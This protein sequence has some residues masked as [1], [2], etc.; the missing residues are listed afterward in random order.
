MKRFIALLL[1]LSMLLTMMGPAFSA[2]A[3]DEDILTESAE[4]FDSYDFEDSFNAFDSYDEEYTPDDE[5]GIDAT[6]LYDEA[7]EDV[8]D[9]VDE[10]DEEDVEEIEDEEVTTKDEEVICPVCGES[11]L[12]DANLLYDENLSPILAELECPICG[13]LFVFGLDYVEYDNSTDLADEFILD[14]I[15]IKF[16]EPWQVPGKEKQLQKE[17]DKVEK[18]GFVE[19][20]GVYVIKVE[21]LDKNPNAILNR[22]KNNS[23]IEYIEPNYIA[24]EG[25]VPNDPNYSAMTLALTILNAQK[26]WDII[27]GD[28]GPII[29][30][31]DSGV[32]PH[33]DL[34]P[35]LP[36]Y[37]AVAGLSPNNDKSGHGTGVAGTV[38]AIGDN[39]L[40]GMGINWNASIL[41]VKIDDANNTFSA[42]NFAK[43]FIWAADNGAKIITTSI[44]FTA[45]ST[46]VKNAIDYA[47]G[48]GCAIFASAGNDGKN[49]LNYPA[50]YPNV[51]AVGGSGNGS[52]R[53]AVSNYG[54]GMGVLANTSYNTV[55]ASGGFTIMSGTSFSTPQVAGLAS[56][57][58]ALNPSLTNEGVYDIIRQ[59]AKG[60]GSYVN[61]EIGYG[62][63][64]IGK[65]LELAQA[66]AGGNAAAAEAAA[67]AAAD[68]A[69][70]AAAEAAAKAAAE[71]A[72]KAQAEAEAKAKAEA[73][74][75]AKAAAEAAAKAAAEAEA[76]AKAEAEAAAKAA[77]EAEAKA[78]AEAEAAAKAAAEAEAKAAAEAEAKAKAEAEAAAKAAAEAEAAAKAA[79]E[80]EAKAKAE[81]EAAA[82][83][84]AEA[85]A[86]KAAAEAEA[87]AKAAAEAEAQAKA[88][89]E[90]EAE[91]LQAETQQKEIRTP[92]VISLTG[93]AEMTLEYDQ[94]YVE[95]G[96]SAV[97]CKG[98]DLTASVKVT[99][100]VNS[101]VAGLYTITYE[102]SDATN[103]AARATRTVIVAPKPPDPPK[104]TAPKIT[105]IGSNPII[106]H[107][108][109]GTPYTEQSARAIDGDGE[110]ISDLVQIS[111]NLNRNVAGTYTINY[112]ITS[113]KTGLS[114][115]TSRTV[116]IVAPNEKKD[117][118]AKYGLSGQA[119]AGSKVTHTGITSGAVGFMDLQVSSID[120]N[121]TITVQLVDTATK[122]AIVTDTFTAAGTKQY[123]IDQSKYEL[124]VAIDKANGNSKY[125]IDLTMPETAATFFFAENEVPLTFIAPPAIQY[126]GSNPIILHL[127]SDTPY[128]EQGARAV[129]CHG[130]DISNK[131]EIFGKPIRDVADTYMITYKVTDDYGFTA[132]STREVR[133]LAPGEYEVGD[134]EVPLEDFWTAMG[135]EKPD[136]AL[137]GNCEWVNVRSKHGAK[138]PII[139]A[140]PAGTSVTVIEEKYGWYLVTD[141]KTEGWIYGE[142]LKF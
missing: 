89:A 33:P 46:T 23:Y 75:A 123:R 27:R 110:N 65:T 43:G 137:I 125:G 78:Q 3:D 77:A 59:G 135:V 74:A 91:R 63:I 31:V 1:C 40:G 2:L 10:A 76:K 118:R 50:R 136:A 85:A 127:D 30:V 133:I 109:S 66:S 105:I 37:A 100:T 44:S 87:A 88:E 124:V 83:A 90:A 128:F 93:F 82:K 116:R 60:N 140:L 7:D 14:E 24:K 80:A 21:D 41:P 121:M 114:A 122:K 51:M 49:G 25:Y 95:M 64:N 73:E 106:L 47:Y 38:G 120:K 126:I 139:A 6:T 86:A 18:V 12:V 16:K 117:P 94:N 115:T 34:P 48:K 81:A 138:Y 108:T 96:Y 56:L 111:G 92:P 8:I 57:V 29:A 67:K 20:L 69:A 98:V 39:K 53:A 42:A 5:H 104:P 119:K 113:P 9:E 72:A 26:G 107:L 112:S 13:D 15:I 32:A 84:A 71:A 28:S 97:D 70:K 102:V 52:S 19:G 55:S 54:A 141:G 129:D 131:V 36:G 45:D 142:Y 58:W 62:F 79:A 61:D 103:L 22:Y 99:N 134:E 35:L 130:V 132:Y 17:I 68:A 101:K 11:F 4:D